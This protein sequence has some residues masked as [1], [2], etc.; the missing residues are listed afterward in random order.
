M[1]PELHRRA[2]LLEVIVGRIYPVMLAGAA[3][4]WLRGHNAAGGGFLGA[5]VAVSA[6]ASYALVFGSAAARARLPFG[7]LGLSALGVAFAAGSGV[8]ALLRGDPF[9]THAWGTL[10]LGVT[11]LAISSVMVFDL[12]VLLCV[13]GALG[14]F[15]LR[16]LEGE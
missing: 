14:G 5:L 16:L 8:P 7:P 9:L 12:G 1:T 11:E 13:W 3:F 4:L 6:T 10:S 15:C 2:V